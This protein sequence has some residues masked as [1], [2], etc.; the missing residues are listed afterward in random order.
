M[1][2]WISITSRMARSYGQVEWKSS[3]FD[4]KVFLMSGSFCSLTLSRHRLDKLASGSF[5]RFFGHNI[6]KRFLFEFLTPPTLPSFGILRR[7][8]KSVFKNSV[9]LRAQSTRLGTGVGFWSIFKYRWAIMGHFCQS[10]FELAKM[11]RYDP[12]GIRIM[13][14]VLTRMSQIDLSGWEKPWPVRVKVWVDVEEQ[15]W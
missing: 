11:S 9:R 10:K 8:V 15:L 14:K 3:F 5:F 4:F 2:G 13:C 6:I 1:I 12:S 7:L